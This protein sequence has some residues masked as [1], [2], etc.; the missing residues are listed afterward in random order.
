MT[1][2]RARKIAKRTD[3]KKYLLDGE[4]VTY[5]ELIQAAARINAD[6]AADWFKQT[7]VAAQILRGVGYTV[8][9]LKDD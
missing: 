9:A 2:E 8:E 1:P 3:Q 4:P 5:R 6:F 7:S